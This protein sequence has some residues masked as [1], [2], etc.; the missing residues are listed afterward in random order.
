V[1][2]LARQEARAL[3]HPRVGTEHLLLGILDHGEGV[4]AVALDRLGIAAEAVRRRVEEIAGSGPGAV[5]HPPLSPRAKEVLA[6]AAQLS[7]ELGHARVGTGHILL[8]IVAEGKGLAARILVDLGADLP[9]VRATVLELLE[10][11]PPGRA[12]PE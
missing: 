12:E 2:T 5:A 4:G 7:R 1:V 3:A 11:P 6:E 9:R 10:G 8:G